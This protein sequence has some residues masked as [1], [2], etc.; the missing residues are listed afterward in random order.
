MKQINYVSDDMDFNAGSLISNIMN[1]FAENNIA[2]YSTGNGR[3]MTGSQV[4]YDTANQNLLTR[5]GFCRK[6]KCIDKNN[7]ELESYLEF[8]LSKDDEITKIDLIN[9]EITNEEICKLSGIDDLNE[10]LS[11]QGNNFHFYFQ[12]V[13]L[14]LMFTNRGSYVDFIMQTVTAKHFNSETEK[15]VAFFSLI[16]QTNERQNVEKYEE[17]TSEIFSVFNSVISNYNLEKV[18]GYRYSELMNL[19][20]E[21]T[22]TLNFEDCNEL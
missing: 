14:E 7:H 2:P 12:K 17:K 3:I 4:Y 6:T 10:V 22:T 9:D 8:R 5:G 15:K 1:T 21:S 11:L 16:D 13:D 18:S 20:P 19:F